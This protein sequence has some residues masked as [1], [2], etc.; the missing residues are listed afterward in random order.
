[1]FV[2]P[3]RNMK[4]IQVIDF[5]FGFFLLFL[6]EFPNSEQVKQIYKNLLEEN[7][8]TQPTSLDQL[9]EFITTKGLEKSRNT[10]CPGYLC[11]VP[12]KFP[13]LVIYHIRR[14]N[15]SFRIG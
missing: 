2:R 6:G 8:P 4:M 3:L 12:G 11:F 5:E 1:M 7:F 15:I 9:L 14:W 10:I 13:F